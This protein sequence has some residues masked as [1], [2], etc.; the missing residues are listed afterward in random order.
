MLKRIELLVHAG[1]PSAR[2]D[3]D[4][5]KA[6]ADAYVGFHGSRI[7]LDSPSG[8]LAIPAPVPDQDGNGHRQ[9]DDTRVI[10][11]PT[12]FVEDTQLA[13]TGIESQLLTS[14]LP[15]TRERC[16]SGPSASFDAAAAVPFSSD[17]EGESHS[18]FGDE[19]PSTPTR[20][21][22]KRKRHADQYEDA[23]ACQRDESEREPEHSKNREE[24]QTTPSTNPS[25]S[26]YLKTPLSD[27][28]AK[29]SGLA[30][31][32]HGSR[33]EDLPTFATAHVD[34]WRALR[35]PFGRTVTPGQ[36]VVTVATAPAVTTRAEDPLAASEPTSEL[37][38]SYSLSDITSE[39]SRAR[40]RPSQRSAS[41]SIVLAK[42]AETSS[43]KVDSSTVTGSSGS[44]FG[45]ETVANAPRSEV[46]KFEPAPEVVV[47]VDDAPCETGAAEA[48]NKSRRIGQST[49]QLAG[50]GKSTVP[51]TSSAPLSASNVEALQVLK[52]LSTSIHAPE[53]EVSVK[54]FTTHI[55]PAL[56]SL[57]SNPDLAGRYVPATATRDLRPLERGHWL[58]DA[59]SLPAERQVKLWQFLEQV[60]TNG[61]PGWGIWCDRDDSTD[62]L[63]VV[64]VYCWGEVVKHTYLLLYVGSGSQI[65][66]LGAR[67]IDAEGVRVVQ[68][69]QV[70]VGKEK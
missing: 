51:Q 18:R 5:Y 8:Q 52:T 70:E 23:E 32:S 26:S 11:S 40:V 67:W 46:A 20:T 35:N 19:H 4:K 59:S 31:S 15:L 24:H 61:G 17:N 28:S 1:A 62:G 14:S 45:A 3:D 12:I 9:E 53:P 56:A 7:A 68:M 2:S 16:S 10:E 50:V 57:E 39:S 37:P 49:L 44:R 21:L 38:T 64:R 47:I 60:I 54:C 65:R 29:K 36:K 69:K 66:K 42:A 41:D 22:G 34:A 25:L 27:R 48:S 58:F 13:I 63:G 30:R 43:S 55:T 6:Q 33:P